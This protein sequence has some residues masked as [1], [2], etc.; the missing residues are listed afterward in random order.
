[1]ISQFSTDIRFVK[2]STNEVADALSRLTVAALSNVG[3]DYMEMSKWQKHDTDIHKLL[4]SHTS[5]KLQQLPLGDTGTLT[6]DMST[7]KPRPVVPPSMSRLVFERFHNLSHPGI[8]ATVKLI[9]DKFVWANMK[10]DIR[11]WA[12]TCLPC[13]KS[14]VHRHTISPSGVFQ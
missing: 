4:E 11:Q 10:S 8:K 12:K 6:C 5:L 14:K 13:Q 9:S 1:F 2:G 3:I 7:G